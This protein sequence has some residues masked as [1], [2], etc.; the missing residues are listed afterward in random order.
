MSQASQTTPRFAVRTFQCPCGESFDTNIYS[1]VNV[2]MEPELLYR[3][4]AGTLNVATCPNCGRK[5]ASAQPFIY[6]DMARGLFA[7]VHPDADLP[8]DD[9]EEL[10]ERLRSVYDQAVAESE[11]LTQPSAGSGSGLHG[12]VEPR[13]R[14]HLPHEDALKRLSPD[15]PPMQVIFGIEDLTALVESLLDAEEKLGRVTLS[16]KASGEA[17]RRRLLSVATRLAE[18]AHC[19]VEVEDLSGEYSVHIYGSRARIR[20][21]GDALKLLNQAR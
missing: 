5:A 21:L 9:R 8:D 4:L 17:E 6:H 2:T 1:T 11:R 7:Y 10:L 14:R 12:A 19:L 20:Q 3:L 18:Q 13:V 15:A 16:T